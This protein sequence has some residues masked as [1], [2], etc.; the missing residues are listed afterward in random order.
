MGTDSNDRTYEIGSQ[1]APVADH[2]PTSRV[3]VMKP[4]GPWRDASGRAL[5]NEQARAML[6]RARTSGRAS[7][8]HGRGPSR[9]KKSR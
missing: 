3:T 8:A 6:D 1:I 9:S 4:L 7:V 5:T 2:A